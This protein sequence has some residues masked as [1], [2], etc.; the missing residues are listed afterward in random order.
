[1][2]KLLRVLSL[3]CPV[4]LGSQNELSGEDITNWFFDFIIDSRQES[5]YF[6]DASGNVVF[7]AAI[8]YSGEY[9]NLKSEFF[10][11]MKVESVNGN[12]SPGSNTIVFS[13]K[14]G[15]YVGYAK[16][17][18]SETHALEHIELDIVSSGIVSLLFKNRDGGVLKINGNKQDSEIQF[19]GTY[20]NSDNSIHSRFTSVWR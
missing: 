14:N 15:I 3:L 11:D 9:I 12:T 17:L 19:N 8:K 20:Y 10:L 16:G 6:T 13:N 1:M 4:F 18:G 7:S 2:T 5:R